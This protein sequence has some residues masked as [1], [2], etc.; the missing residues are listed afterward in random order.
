MCL[1][2]SDGIMCSFEQEDITSA[3]IYT[4]YTPDSSPQTGV[5]IILL[6][7]QSAKLYNRARR[8]EPKKDERNTL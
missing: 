1:N 7:S 4:I 3:R 2:A 5:F 8:T 6:Q